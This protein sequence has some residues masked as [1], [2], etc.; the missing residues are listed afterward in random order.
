[1]NREAEYFQKVTFKGSYPDVASVPSSFAIPVVAFTG[2]SNSGKS[3]LLSALCNHANLA[4]VSKT[5]GKTRLLNYFLVPPGAVPGAGLYLVDM[6]GYGFAKLPRPEAAKLRRLIDEFL[7]SAENLKLIVLVLDAKRELASEERGI[8][9]YCRANNRNLYLA[10]TK[11]DMLN[12]R[13]R[14]AAQKVWR[15]DGVAD[16]CRPISSKDKRGI[17]EL[18]DAIRGLLADTEHKAN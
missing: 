15:E 7:A 3:S 5:A 8:V 11:W 4:R 14:A 13:E 17:P 10:R 18:V 2:R 9:E 6:P 1:M 12:Q 16:I